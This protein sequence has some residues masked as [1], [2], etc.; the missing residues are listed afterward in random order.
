MTNLLRNGLIESILW[1]LIDIEKRLSYSS[2]ITMIWL[3]WL[4]DII[5]VKIPLIVKSW[6]FIL[7]N[8][9]FCKGNK[10]NMKVK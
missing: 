7:Y 8:K 10:K 2:L 3:I 5:S 4:M 6:L 9:F 1:L